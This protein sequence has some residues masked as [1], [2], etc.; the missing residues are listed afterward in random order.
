MEMEKLPSELQELFMSTFNQSYFLKH[1]KSDKDKSPRGKLEAYLQVVRRFGTL[2]KKRKK[3]LLDVGCGYGKFLQVA[4]DG[5]DTYGVDPS[6]YAISRAKSATPKTIFNVA[7]L[8]TFQSKKKYDIITAFDILEHTENVPVS[9]KKI[10]SLL[11][12]EGIF[13]CVVPVYDGPLG[14]IGGLLDRDKTHI[15]KLSR[16]EWMKLFE[17]KF[18]ILEKQGAIRYSLT[19]EVYFHLMQPWLFRWGQAIM[20]VMKK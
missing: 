8:E 16:W 6:E 15:Q 20:V 10:V 1:Y 3:S 9:L 17:N 4:K 19:G 2:N 7:T 5:F 12:P 11:Q 14:F 13:I 18:T